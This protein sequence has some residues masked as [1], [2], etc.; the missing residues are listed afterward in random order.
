MGRTKR[1]RTRKKQSL[2][3]PVADGEVETINL[4]KWLYRNGFSDPLKLKLRIFPFTGRGVT[5]ASPIKQGDALIHVPMSV[6]IT[7]NTLAESGVFKHVCGKGRL[8]I[9]TLLAFFLALEKH[10]HDKSSWFYYIRTLPDPEP[11]LP[12][13]VADDVFKLCI[14]RIPRELR[15]NIIKLRDN[16]QENFSKLKQS[17]LTKTICSCCE[18]TVDNVL[19]ERLFRWAYVLVNTRAV[20][21][22]PR[23]VSFSTGTDISILSDEPSMALCPFLDMFNHHYL[24][25]TVADVVL[26]QGQ[27]FY[28]LRTLRSFKKHEQFFICYGAHD[29]V[30]LLMEYGFFIPDNPN[31]CVKFSFQE[32]LLILKLSFNEKQYKFIRNHCFD[33]KDIYINWSGPSFN[34]KAICFIHSYVDCLNYS[35]II[36][37]EAYP[38][39]FSHDV[40]ELL[41]KLL[42]YK[43]NEFENDVQHMSHDSVG[44]NDQLALIKDF[45][46][47][48]IKYAKKLLCN[49]TKNVSYIQ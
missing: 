1:K 39:D 43:L 20:Y 31:D 11:T 40:E 27:R 13:T 8:N 17:I 23:Q 41:E 35:S 48:R 33:D 46:D 2:Y 21:I 44:T 7:C 29:N 12:W 10:K 5:S 42:N 28:E 19:N 45:L 4:K 38:N 30:K 47:F 24:A 14:H 16:Y 22:D 18:S 49:L 26:I 9:H 34:L 3:I 36:F 6:L 15:E 25:Q 37:S 32:L